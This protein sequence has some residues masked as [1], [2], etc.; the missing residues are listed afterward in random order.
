MT[1]FVFITR[2]GGNTL[3]AQFGGRNQLALV[4][5]EVKACSAPTPIGK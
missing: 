1:S 3:T 5:D 4:A 2:S